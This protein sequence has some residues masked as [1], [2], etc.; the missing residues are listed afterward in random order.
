MSKL[1]LE[2]KR[3]EARGG[4]SCV[5]PAPPLAAV[6]VIEASSRAASTRSIWDKTSSM[7][8]ALKTVMWDRTSR[9]NASSWMSVPEAA[10]AMAATLSALKELVKSKYNT[11]SPLEAEKADNYNR[12]DKHFS[13]IFQTG[14]PSFPCD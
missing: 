10:D 6:A 14:S 4:N 5:G 2:C 8:C 13:Q 9:Q 7:L 12:K 1:G 11:P 3:R